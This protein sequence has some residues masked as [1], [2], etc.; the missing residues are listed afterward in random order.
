MQIDLY[1]NG[2]VR[3]TPNPENRLEKSYVRTLVERL[4]WVYTNAV[5]KTRIGGVSIIGKREA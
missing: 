3:I 5:I 1:E 2:Q 4:T